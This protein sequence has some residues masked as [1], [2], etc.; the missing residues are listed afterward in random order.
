MFLRRHIPR[1]RPIYPRYHA[2]YEHNIRFA[3]RFSVV[4]IVEENQVDFVIVP[5]TD[6]SRRMCS[7]FVI[8]THG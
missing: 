3:I 7:T 8:L 1:I 2:R 5:G 4:E 6:I